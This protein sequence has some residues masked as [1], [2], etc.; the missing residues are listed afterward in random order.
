MLATPL[1]GRFTG[2]NKRLVFAP[3]EWYFWLIY[4]T[5]IAGAVCLAYGLGGLTSDAFLLNNPAVCRLTAALLLLAAFF[6]YVSLERITIDLGERRYRRW[7]GRAFLPSY[8]FGKLDELESVVLTAEDKPFAPGHAGRTAAY[9]IVLV[10]KGMKLPVMVAEE[11]FVPLAPHH[12]LNAGA[13]NSWQ[14][15]QSFAQA[16][17]L[18]MIDHTHVSSPHPTKLI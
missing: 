1:S 14:R 18:P 2:E 16:L 15:A 8:A 12:A 4:A 13:A 6:A 5:A 11:C 10:W 9:R 7:F 17:G 3:P